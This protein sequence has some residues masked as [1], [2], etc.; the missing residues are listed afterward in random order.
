MPISVSRLV[1]KHKLSPKDLKRYFDAS[2][3]EAR[4]EVAKL[5]A[6]IK[7][8]IQEGIDRNR[9]DYRLFKAMD[10]AMDQPFYQVSYTQLKGLLTGK[11]DDKKVMETVNSWG[12]T[13]LLPYKMNGGQICC[14]A[15]GKPERVLNI[16]FLT[17]IY[18]PIV[19][20]YHNIRLAKLFNDRNL[21]PLYKYEPVQFT[22][23]NRVKCEIV[24]QVV[25]KQAAW[26]DYKADERQSISQMLQY[27]ICINFPREAWFHETQEDA[28]GKESVVREGL[29]FDM[30][31]PSRMYYDP[32]HRASTLNSNSGCE[33]VG[34]WK[35]ERYSDINDNPHYWNKDKIAIGAHS[36]L[37]LDAPGSDF[38]TEVYP[39]TMALPARTGEGSGGVGALNR[40]DDA[41]RFYGQGT[42]ATAATLVTNHFCRL[43]PADWGLGTYKHP[44]WMRFIFASDS[45]VIYAE[46]LAFDRFPTY[47]YDAD[48]NRSRFRS[49]TLEVMPFQDQVGNLL[50]QWGMAVR[51]NLRNP[52]FVDKEKVPVNALLALENHGNKMYSGREYIP[53][54]S[55]ENYRMKTDQKEAFFTPQLTHHNTGEIAQLITG[56]LDMLDRVMQLSPQEIGQAASHEQTAE[57]SRI[58]EGNMSTR[59]AFTGSFIDDAIYAKKRMIYDATM[60]YADDD[61]M[62]G[63]SSAHVA[64]EEEFKALAQKLQLTIMDDSDY[65]PEQPGTMR[66]VSLKKSAMELETFASTRD[67]DTR[68]NNPAIA[69]A[70]SQIFL[71]IAN[72]PVLI[73]SIGTTQLVELLN[74]VVVASGL[75]KE[76]RLQGKPL[77]QIQQQADPEEQNAQMQEVLKTFAEQVRSLVEQSQQQ[78]LEAAAQQ[79]QQIVGQAM[80]ATAQQMEPV[81]Q[82]V[83]QVAQVAVKANADNQAQQ[84][85]IEAVTQ[86]ITVL[87]Q[88]IEAVTQAAAAAMTATVSQGP[89][90][91]PMQ[92]VEPVPQVGVPV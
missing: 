64:S 6:K 67:A 13:H 88:K 55:T 4:P 68:I 54:N 22:K 53:F 2:T 49:L 7:D 89:P 65:N 38:L 16:P 8:T 10:W 45:T 50:S 58:I 46:P 21:V 36:W 84:Q 57:E 83:Q 40:E 90:Q 41:A 75:P 24:T 59:V 33:F 29:R 44:I 80:Q 61:I 23:E 12:L 78:T 85:Q 31:H 79:T 60:E 87:N 42:S 27:G 11:P 43:V 26:F 19:M 17:N 39:C 92:P 5:V 86:A 63:I 69:S 14:G 77:E 37:G 32:Y 20:A 71:S 82:G 52:I 66:K 62:V 47:A 3:I 73:Q 74:Q 30:P 51:E 91:I 9:R 34:H 1:K 18:V 56:V 72:N 35:L 25:Q 48:F 15:D 28:T 81:A 76:F 70:M